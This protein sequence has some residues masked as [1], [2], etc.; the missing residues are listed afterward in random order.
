MDLSVTADPSSEHLIPEDGS[1]Q[2]LLEDLGTSL[3]HSP[4]FVTTGVRTPLPLC[5]QN[6]QALMERPVAIRLYADAL[7][8]TTPSSQLRELWR[9]LESGF[10]ATGPD[11]LRLL[12]SCSLCKELRFT[13]QEQLREIY[14][15]RGRSSHANGREAADDLAALDAQASAR[16]PRLQDLVEAMILD[17]IDWG[18]RS[19]D[20]RPFSGRAF[21]ASDGIVMLQQQIP[22][23]NDR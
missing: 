20:A 8:M 22:S 6:V 17:K 13:P 5:E 12:A 4:L 15:L 14:V 11:L 21:V 1:D 16:I 19:V 9:V 3:V 23:S 7:G 18:S 2:A 10:R